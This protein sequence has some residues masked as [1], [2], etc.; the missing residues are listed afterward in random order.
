MIKKNPEATAFFEPDA[1]QSAPKKIPSA[2]A[3]PANRPSPAKAAVALTEEADSHTADA[4]ISP[5]VDARKALASDI[6]RIRSIRK[7]F[8]T[9]MQKLAR[10]KKPG[11]HTHWF[12]D[13]PGR[14]DEAKSNGW[15]HRLDK[16][17]KPVKRVVGRGRDSM[18]LY[19]YAMDLPMIFWEE[20]MQAR[21]DAAQ[22]RLDEIKK[23]PFRSKPGQAKAADQ[24][25]FYSPTEAPVVQMSESL[26]RRSTPAAT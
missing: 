7:P 13:E 16:E 23:T 25:K 3:P 8:G 21:H 26:V 11:Y 20:D 17:G 9:M 15:A 14:V 18:A 19:G 12:S 2:K 6:A 5:E 22:A 4:S 10:P 24:G 1:L